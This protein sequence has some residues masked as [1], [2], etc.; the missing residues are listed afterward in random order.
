MGILLAGLANLMMKRGTFVLS[1]THG[2]QKLY[3]KGEQ[4]GAPNFIGLRPSPVFT[5][6]NRCEDAT[7]Y[8]HWLTAWH[9]RQALHRSSMQASAI[10]IEPVRSPKP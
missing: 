7:H 5:M 9:Y 1:Q 4:L 8:S 2:D 6:V 3:Y 10:A